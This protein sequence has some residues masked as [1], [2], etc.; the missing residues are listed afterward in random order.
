MEWEGYILCTSSSLVWLKQRESE[1]MLSLFLQVVSN[2]P[3]FVADCRKIDCVAIYTSRSEWKNY[4]KKN[5]FKFRSQTKIGNYFY[6]KL[7]INNCGI[8][9]I[10]FYIFL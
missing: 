9:V 2:N 3:H 6:S 4:L 10:N 5:P 7:L 8:T 1:Q